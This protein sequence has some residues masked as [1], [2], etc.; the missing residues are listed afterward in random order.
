M[1]KRPEYHRIMEET[2]MKTSHGKTSI[3]Y[4]LRHNS[5][6]NAEGACSGIDTNVFYPVQDVFSPSEERMIQKMCID[7][8]VMLMCLEWGLIHERHGIW[9]GTT[10]NQRRRIRGSLG[11]IVSEPKL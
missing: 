10:P 6:L 4:T 8:P 7:C 1:K 11:W 5:K 3:R 2:V 9:G